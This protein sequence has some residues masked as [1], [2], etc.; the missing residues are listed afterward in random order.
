MSYK[1]VGRNVGHDHGLY[2]LQAG[3]LDG[4]EEP[5]TDSETMAAYYIEK[6]RTVQPDGPYALGGLSSGGVVAFEMAQQLRA[7]GETVALV[8]L[9]DSAVPNSGYDKVT[10]SWGCLRDLLRDLPSWLRGFWQLTC[11]QQFELI[12]IAI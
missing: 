11:S 5:L 1:H 8:A 3:W 7:M 2:S 12:S 10:W 4:V 9:L 6:M